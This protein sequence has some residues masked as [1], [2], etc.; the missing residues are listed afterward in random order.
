MHALGEA[1]GAAAFR[2]GGDAD[3]RCRHGSCGGGNV[4]A[5]VGGRSARRR[6]ARG[7][8]AVD[9]P[10]PSHCRR[11]GDGLAAGAA[12]RRRARLGGA[13][14][15]SRASCAP[16]RSRGC[17]AWPAA[18]AGGARGGGRGAAGDRAPTPCRDDAALAALAS[19]PDDVVEVIGAALESRPA[20]ACGSRQSKR[21]HVCV[22]RRASDALKHGL[23]DAEAVVRASAV[24]AFG[25]LGNVRRRALWSRTCRTDPDEGVRRRA[26]AVCARH[27]WAKEL[28]ID[29]RDPSGCSRGVPRCRR[30][31]R[32]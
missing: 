19:L 2:P 29:E 16:W 5:V 12:D 3:S 1:R 28:R 18:V 9:R 7:G 11:A 10:G 31:Q 6:A 14:R 32:S 24:A 21:W 30:P 8:R 25:R 22:I 15:T 4:G 27:G 26:S 23:E 20:A 17:G 13:P